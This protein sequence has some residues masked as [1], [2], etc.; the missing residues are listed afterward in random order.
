MEAGRGDPLERL[1]HE[2]VIRERG[3][4][5]RD[6]DEPRQRNQGEDADGAPRKQRAYRRPPFGGKGVGDH[7]E[8][9]EHDRD[10]PL[11]QRAGAH[12]R[13]RDDG[14]RF[15]EPEHRRG[16]AQRERAVEDRGARIHQ[17]EQRRGV[18]DAGEPAR[19]R[20]PAP[21]GEAEQ[22]G[23]G[24]E[25]RRVGRQA[26]RRLSG[27]EQLHQR[28]GGGEVD[29]RLVEVGKPVQVRHE[30]VVGLRHLARHLGIAAFV[31]IEQAVPVEVPAER[32]GREKQEQPRVRERS[33]RHQ[34]RAQCSD[35]PPAG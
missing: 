25:R 20:A 4:A 23:N 26:R 9:G 13:P 17:R 1:A 31:G 18:G 8:Q 35:C 15:E 33:A 30:I 7:D 21:P 28:G 29:D 2:H 24:R 3:D 5:D 10:R 12:R 19:L 14:A 11:R 16:G 34:S 32:D 6:G 22:E 27:S